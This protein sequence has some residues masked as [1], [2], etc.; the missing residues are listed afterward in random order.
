MLGCVCIIYSYSLTKSVFSGINTSIVFDT[1]ILLTY[2][3][4]LF[5]Y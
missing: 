5:N 3:I 1:G 2:K 4:T